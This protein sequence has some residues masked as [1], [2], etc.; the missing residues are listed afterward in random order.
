MNVKGEATLKICRQKLKVKNYSDITI[1]VYIG[2]ITKFIL[3][4]DKSC[5]HLNAK[6]FQMYID[7]YEFTSTSQQNQIINALKFLYTYGLNR[8]YGKV[9]F[10]RPRKEK[11]LPRVIDNE[12]LLRKLN[13]V[14]NLKHKTILS[15]TYSVGLRVSEILNLKLEDIDSNRMVINIRNAKGRKDRIVPLSE[16]ML[17]M[18]RTYYMQYRPKEFMFNGQSSEKYSSTSCNMLVKK[19][20][21]REYH[22]HLLRHSCF[23]HLLESGTDLRIIQEIA[24]HSS[25]KT[26][27]IYTHV[28]KK[29][30]NKV[31]LPI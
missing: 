15:L 17:N 30:L 9:D 4:Q 12:F 11:K 20:I 22:M 27:E 1:K 18:L 21:G 31:A 28:S 3:S 19:H 29:L 2:Y 16:T 6:D 23:T 24:G 26:T 5:I 10:T 7:T 13:V 8:K 25:S 14:K